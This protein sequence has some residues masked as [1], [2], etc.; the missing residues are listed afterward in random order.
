MTPRPLHRRHR[1][2]VRRLRR[3]TRT[4]RPRDSRRREIR[5]ANGS[6]Q[7]RACRADI[8]RRAQSLTSERQSNELAD[9]RGFSEP[10]VS[11][12]AV[13]L[14]Y[15][16]VAALALMLLLGVGT[17]VASA[18]I[19]SRALSAGVVFF[20]A[21]AALFGL[22]SVPLLRHACT[23]C[24]IWLMISQMLLPGPLSYA[25]LLGGLAVFE[26]AGWADDALTLDAG[27]LTSRS[28]SADARARSRSR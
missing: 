25:S 10:R 2:A 7:R 24:G 22:Y 4:G 21:T 28:V 11:L 8:G 1:I 13:R 12:V 9:S 23:V 3:L 16:L 27:P 26:I 19:V 17:S 6:S 18:Q 5:F 15:A 20:L 14:A